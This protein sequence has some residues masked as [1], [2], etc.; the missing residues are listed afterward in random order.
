MHLVSLIAVAL[1][2]GA[3][4][5]LNMWYEADLDALMKR[6]CLRPIPSGKSCQKIKLLFLV[7]LHLFYQLLFFIFSQT[8]YQQLCYSYNFILCCIYNMVKTKNS[9]KYC[10]WR[11]SWS[12]SSHY[13]MD[14]CNRKYN[15]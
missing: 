1:G 10:Y 2:A 14:Y 8:F 3:A 9:T 15:F 6:T 12:F 4:G 13:W 5:T 7:Y 11:S